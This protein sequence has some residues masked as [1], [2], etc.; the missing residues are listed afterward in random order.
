MFERDTDQAGRP[1]GDFLLRDRALEVDIE[2]GELAELLVGETEGRSLRRL[3]R[4]T[5][6]V[7]EIALRR[8]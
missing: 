3:L 2:E 5:G 8:T 6:R 1:Q 4:K 7:I